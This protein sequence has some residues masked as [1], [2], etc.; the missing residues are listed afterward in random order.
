MPQEGNLAL[1]YKNLLKKSDTPGDSRMTLMNPNDF[2][3]VD[4][5]ERLEYYNL[6]ELHLETLKAGTSSKQLAGEGIQC[7]LEA[8]T[9]LKNQI[10]FKD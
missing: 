10:A 4:R 6:L 7:Q 5:K 1:L 8:S 3:F 9:Y 2:F